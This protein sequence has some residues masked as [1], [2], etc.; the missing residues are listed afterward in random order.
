MD[1]RLTG[2]DALDEENFQIV[3]RAVQQRRPLAF[4]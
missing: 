3:L 4:I 2:P 1:I